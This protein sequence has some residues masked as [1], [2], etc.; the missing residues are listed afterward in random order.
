MWGAIGPPIENGAA[1]AV[2]LEK[3]GLELGVGLVNSVHDNPPVTRIES[4][5]AVQ[6]EGTA[7]TFFHGVEESTDAMDQ[8]LAAGPSADGELGVAKEGTPSGSVGKGHR[9]GDDSEEDVRDRDGAD[10]S[11]GLGQGEASPEAKKRPAPV[12]EVSQEDSVEKGTDVSHE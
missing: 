12:W 1:S 10:A 7:G 9:P 8:L 6:E 11:S 5:D 4:V 3:E 2:E